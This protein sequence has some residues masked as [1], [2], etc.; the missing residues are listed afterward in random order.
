MRPDGRGARRAATDQ[1][2]ARLHRPRPTGRCWSRPGGTMVLCTATVDD[3]VPRWMR[4]SGKGWVTAEY[5]MLPGSSGER[6]RR[7]VSKG[8]P[9]GPHPRDPAADRPLA[10]G[11]VRHGAAR[12]A[13]GDRRLRRAAGRRRHPHGV[14]Q[15]RLP[16]AARRARPPR[17]ARAIWPSTRSRE[18]CA[19]VSVGHRRRRAAA[20]PRPTSRT[21][22]AEVDM[23]VVMTES[24]RFIEVQ[25]T[26]EGMA[27]SRERARRAAARWPRSG[28]GEIVGL[29]NADDRRAAAPSPSADGARRR[30]RRSGWSSASANP[31]KVAEIAAILGP[32]RRAACRDRRSLA[33]VVE[34]ADTLEGNARL[35]AVAIAEAT[36]P[37]AVADDTGLEVDALGG[38]PGVLLG[39]LRRRGRDLRRQRGQAAGRARAAG[40][41]IRPRGGPV[42][43]GG[44]GALAR[45]ARGRGRGRGRGPHRRSSRA[46][47][48][49]FGYDPVFVPD[50]DGAPGAA[51]SPRWHADGEARRAATAAA[52]SAPSPRCR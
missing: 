1:L 34:D 51:P 29:Q 50:A 8:S 38:A 36:G 11:G 48:D 28:I 6:I 47:T 26:A 15:R 12:R 35:K 24:G 14:D 30:I 42:P 17:A 18:A 33:E 13:P 44:P 46:A 3:D 45:R 22:R 5:S 31:D 41:A 4:G 16:R 27:F 23:N 52:P 9:G 43:H 2:R 19:A 40:A 25:G 32:T 21:R 10:A 7:E 39:P 49:G 20:R 37:P